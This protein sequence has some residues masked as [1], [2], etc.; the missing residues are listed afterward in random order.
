MAF[1][2][3]RLSPPNAFERAYQQACR[4]YGCIACHRLCL[5]K[6]EHCGRMEFNHRLHSG[7]TVGHLWGYGLGL[8]HHQGKASG[9]RSLEQMR[10]KYGP[11]L[12]DDKGGFHAT[13]GSDQALQNDQH[14][15][16]G[17]PRA[18]MPSQ[19]ER[20]LAEGFAPRKP[21]RCARPAN[22]LPRNWNR[23]RAEGSN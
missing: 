2:S 5:P 13:F 22:M 8:Y 17:I 4:D 14:D 18:E 7:Q 10:D 16:L 11:N 19:R 23:E 9:G 1:G 6:S 21:S 12:V 3:K 15:A 20:R